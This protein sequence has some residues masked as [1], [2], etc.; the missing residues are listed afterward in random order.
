MQTENKYAS[1]VHCYVYCLC[2]H[3]IL[4]D[5]LFFFFNKERS[6]FFMSFLERNDRSVIDGAEIARPNPFYRKFSSTGC[7]CLGRRAR[8]NAH[9]GGFGASIGEGAWLTSNA[10]SISVAVSFAVGCC[11][12]FLSRSLTPVRYRSVRVWWDR[13]NFATA[14]AR[15]LIKRYATL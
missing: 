14:L 3:T 1:Y 2:W 13:V 7:V 4:T 11:Q 10:T 8:T 9:V 5:L 12:M 6:N 15:R